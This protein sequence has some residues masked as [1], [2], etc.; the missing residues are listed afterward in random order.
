MPV[1]EAGWTRALIAEAARLR[2]E[3]EERLKDLA[4]V[5]P[6][7]WP[8][9]KWMYAVRDREL[10][11][12]AGGEAPVYEGLRVGIPSPWD[13]D[14][15]QLVAFGRVKASGSRATR[16]SRKRSEMSSGSSATWSGRNLRTKQAKRNKPPAPRA[17]SPRAAWFAGRLRGLCSLCVDAHSPPVPRARQCDACR[18][19]GG[20]EW[21][22]GH[23]GAG[24]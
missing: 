2:L 12:P 10:L 8:W 7:A 3:G 17:L 9:A 19:A 22:Q 16:F 6:A 14:N 20:K 24:T 5:D 4:A 21:L 18:G 1:A 13:P 23:G 11:V 15:V